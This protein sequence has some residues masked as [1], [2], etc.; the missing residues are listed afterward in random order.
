MSDQIEETT[1]EASKIPEASGVVVLKTKTDGVIS[2]E[3][4]IVGEV[5]PTEV[6]TLLEL[7]VLAWRKRIGLS[8]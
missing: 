4:Q 2:T 3:I 1:D 8:N 6:Q 7:G 5:E